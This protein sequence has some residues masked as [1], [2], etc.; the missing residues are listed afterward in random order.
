[1]LRITVGLMY[2]DEQGVE[3]SLDKAFERYLKAAENGDVKAQFNV[4]FCYST[5]GFGVM[6]NLEKA[7]QYFTLA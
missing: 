1:M 2:K 5:T 4:G 6:K 3:K 7:V